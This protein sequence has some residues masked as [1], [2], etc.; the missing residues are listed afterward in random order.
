MNA[1][2]FRRNRKKL[3]L[4]VNKLAHIM[5]VEPRSVWRWEAGDHAPPGSAVR[6]MEWLLLGFKPPEMK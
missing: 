3:R 5:N 4:S 2:D 6:I 1:D